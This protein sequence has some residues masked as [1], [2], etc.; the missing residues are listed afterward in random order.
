MSVVDIFKEA[1]MYEDVGVRL[2]EIG[3][4]VRYLL[5]VDMINGWELIVM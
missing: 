5:T 2:A 1:D 4:V 3:L